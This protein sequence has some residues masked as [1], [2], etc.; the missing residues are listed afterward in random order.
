MRFLALAMSWLLPA[1]CAGLGTGHARL[2]SAGTASPGW[3]VGTLEQEEVCPSAPSLD[4]C[5][6]SAPTARG[7]L[8]PFKLSAGPD[9]WA[10]VN[11]VTRRDRKSILAGVASV[12][13]RTW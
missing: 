2:A 13:F 11:I 9:G 4:L 1:V 6:I 5:T 3:L 12:T 10:W 8:E 7:F